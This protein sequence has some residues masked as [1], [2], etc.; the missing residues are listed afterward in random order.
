MHI[1]VNQPVQVSPS[2]H[3][4]RQICSLTLHNLPVVMPPNRSACTK[5]L[6]I[7]DLTC[8]A[9]PQNTAVGLCFISGL[10]VYIADAVLPSLKQNF[11]SLAFSFKSAVTKWQIALNTCSRLHVCPWLVA[12]L[13]CLVFWVLGTNSVTLDWI[14][15]CCMCL[16]LVVCH[17]P[18][19]QHV[20][21]RCV[22]M[23]RSPLSV[24]WSL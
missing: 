8:L 16:Y 19:V 11:A 14:L 21:H 23:C 22:S 7:L 24:D 6:S 1:F 9:L 10:L 2:L 20:I 5:W 13:Y 15:L 18:D 3:P 17:L 12:K 4:F